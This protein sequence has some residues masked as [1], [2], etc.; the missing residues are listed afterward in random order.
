MNNENNSS[1]DW[2]CV[3]VVSVIIICITVFRIIG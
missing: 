3:V 1:N 2:G